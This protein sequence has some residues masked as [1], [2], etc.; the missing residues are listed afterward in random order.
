MK[1]DSFVVSLYTYP[2]DVADEGLDV[3]LGRIADLAGCDEVMLTPSYH[4]SDYFLPHH[5]THPIYFG[6]NGAIYFRP[7]SSRYADTKIRPRVSREVTDDGY[8]DR[9]VE[10]IR[11]KGLLFSAWMVYVFDDYLTQTYPELA[12]HDMFGT[13]HIG[14]VSTAPP[15]VRSYFLALT[16][17]VVERF[18]PAAVWV[19]SLA[20]RAFSFR[21]KSRADIA[22]RCQFLL[23]L[24]FNPAAMTYATE[25]GLDAEALRQ[26]LAAWM[27]PH[28][29]AGVDDP[30]EPVDAAWLEEAFDG[31]LQRYMELAREQTTELWLEAASI[32]RGAG[33]RLQT[34]LADPVRAQRDD[35]D[36]RT[37]R[38]IDRLSYS[39]R[40]G[41]AAASR[42]REL[43]SQIAPGGSVF[44]RPEGDFR[45]VG[46]ISAQLGEARQAGAGGV[47]LY[48]Y[49]LLTEEQLRNIG[50]AVRSS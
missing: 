38:H 14:A 28:L 9:I 30:D 1:S 29:A 25:A 10:E 27:R 44:L 17:E 6:E 22:A 33:V 19:E 26:D 12:R 13:P 24:D 41:E 2:W 50:Q 46:P 8:F 21:G 18:E 3:S 15:D 31:R 49:G 47:T 11:K 34:D 45:A 35:L 42:L 7:D 5:P 20:R 23:G 16:R 40:D 4:R 43:E 32:I 39:L 48:N 37:N 36:P